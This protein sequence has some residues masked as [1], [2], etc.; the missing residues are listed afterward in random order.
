MSETEKGPAVADD[1]VVTEEAV[2]EE[3]QG[4][5][6]DGDEAPSRMDLAVSIER[7]GPCKKHVRVV[8]PRSAIDAV[9]DGEVQELVD[10]AAVPGF[11]KGH[12][13]DQLIRKRF[14]KELSEQV[15]QKVLMR[16]LEQISEDED[17]QPINE[18][19]LDLEA[20]EVPEEGDFEYEFD[21]E[22][23][24]EFELPDYKGLQ[25]ERPV[26]EVTEQ[27]ID[28]YLEEY[29]EQYGQLEPVDE[30][31]APGDSVTLAIEF[32][33]G[34]QPLKTIEEISL[35]VRPTLRFQDG[36][37]ADFDKLMVGAR[38]DDV[39]EAD[40][41]VSM[42]ADTIAMRGETV[43]ARCTVLD[44]KRLRAQELSQEFLD[45]IGIES[46]EKLRKQ[47]REMLER[48]VTYEQRQA[49][50]RQ[51]LEKIT[52]SADWDLP[53]DL[54]RKQVENALRRE[55]LEMQQSGFTPRDIRA[56]E[57]DLR[58][59]SISMTRQNLK[60]HFVLDR[61]AEQEQ[62]DVSQTEIDV[63]IALMAMQR[64]ENPRR[65]RARL[66]KSGVIENLDAQIR[67]RKA[68]DVILQHARFKDVPMP[69]ARESGVEAIDRSICS[70]ITDTPVEA[71]EEHD[72]DHDGDHDHD[73]G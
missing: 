6:P 21:I 17:L 34:G 73:H 28:H 18:P 23:R 42:E 59:R 13:P 43:Q 70:T 53:E 61:V 20:F 32:T 68:V 14:K 40:L 41:T 16:S 4:D 1:E 50:R 56:R 29:L 66:Q 15:K 19:N 36:E 62:I 69:V 60:E 57:N 39:R 33:H 71:E 8:V 35:R 49:T 72:H 44:V 25:I 22:V 30:P 7:S 48:Q 2:I 31:A 51:V 55:V 11:R 47:V 26:R 65:M 24:P 38:A 3:T 67:E 10:S 27:D 9:L 54:V 45:R 52:E 37:L 46:V 58:Q 5:E 63:E 64:G 12:V